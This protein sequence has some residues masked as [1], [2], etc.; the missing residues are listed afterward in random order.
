M[1][2]LMTGLTG[3]ALFSALCVGAGCGKKAPPPVAPVRAALLLGSEPTAPMATRIARSPWPVTEGQ[4]EGPEETYFVE[5][6]RDNFGGNEFQ[7][8]SNPQR[9]FR[10]F[11]VG[12]RQK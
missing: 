12:A 7:E 11:R 8:R 3:L 6:Y 10:S 2:R 5:Y 1:L 4:Y 9:Q